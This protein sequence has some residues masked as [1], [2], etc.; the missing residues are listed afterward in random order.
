M[1]RKKL[2]VAGVLIG[3]TII[4]LVS[5]FMIVSFGLDLIS[6]IKGRTHFDPSSLST[7][8]FDNSTPEA[9]AVSIARLNGGIAFG[10]GTVKDVYLT[11]DGKYWVVKFYDPPAPKGP[12]YWTVTIDAKTLMSKKD[13]DEWRSLDELKASYIAQIQSMG[14]PCR[15][16]Q[17]I[18]MNGK[19]VWKVP[20]VTEFENGTDKTFKYI[21]VDLKTG[22][23]KNTL[24]NFNRAAGT[25]GWL[26]LKEVDAV[27]NKQHQNYSE[28]SQFRDV[29][30]DLYQE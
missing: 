3:G 19:E 20:V 30:R 25:D 7:T 5:A 4:C 22:K 21:Y 1:D 12:Y 23:S 9:T 8:S 24:E 27:I 10:V 29:L 14:N 16:P 18:T 13:D 2:L 6:E 26:T 28:P 11:S 15:K 17:K